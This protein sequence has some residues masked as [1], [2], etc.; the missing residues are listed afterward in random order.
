MM[1][2]ATSSGG[3]II[4]ISRALDDAGC[5]SNELF[6][7]VGLD[8]HHATDPNSRFDVKK[9]G[10]LWD[11]VT[12]QTGNEAIGLSVASYIKPTTFHALGYSIWASETLKDALQRLVNYGRMVSNAGT[13]ELVCYG[14]VYSIRFQVNQDEHGYKLVADQALDAFIASMVAICRELSGAAFSPK[15]MFLERSEPTDLKSMAAFNAFFNCPIEFGAAQ[16]I[17]EFDSTVLEG[18]LLTANAELASKSDQVVI[19]YLARLEWNDIVTQVQAKVIEMLPL[20]EPSQEKVAKSLNLSLRNLQRKLQ[21]EGTHYTQVV[22]DVRRDLARQY[23]EQSHITINE[24]CYMLGF[25]NLSSFC[26][27]FKRWTGMAPGQYRAQKS[28]KE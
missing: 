5:D 6:S 14:D 15:A 12:T 13:L 10:Q 8:L 7:Q 20:G 26:R 3:W 2:K 22:E 23:L 28:N 16:T 27:A 4:A 17:I 19:D 25:A 24:I 1:R 9:M 18:T 21:Q 11:I